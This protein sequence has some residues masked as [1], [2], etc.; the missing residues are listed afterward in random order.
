M[1]HLEI[2]LARIE[3]LYGL[4]KPEARLATLRDEL[5]LMIAE[6]NDSEIGAI[7]E[8]ARAVIAEL[9]AALL[10]GDFLQT[11]YGFDPSLDDSA[12]HF[13]PDEEAFSRSGIFVE[14]V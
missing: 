10:A 9:E 2:P 13:T 3:R 8:A 14:A 4:L 11:T 12:P 5:Q 7:C 1:G 6:G